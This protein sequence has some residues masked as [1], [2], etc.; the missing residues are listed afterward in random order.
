M[1]K[2]VVGMSGGVDSA[3]AALLLKE[4][5]YEV[6]GVLLRTWVADDGTEGRCCEIDDARRVAWKLHIPFL[7]LNCLRDF[8]E[9]VTRP[10][11][12]DYLAG[13]TPNPCTV[14]NRA[15]KW[16]KL[17]YAAN[18]MQAEFVATGHYASVVHLPNGRYSVQRAVHAEKDQTYMLYQLSQ[19]MLSRTLMPLATYSKA[20]VR[21]MAAAAGLAVADKKDSQEICFVPDGDYAGYIRNNSDMPIPGEGN[22][23]DSEGRILGRHQ[24]ILHYTVGQR[25]GLGIALGH[26]VFV[27]EIRADKNEVVLSED[28]D[29][30]GREVLCGELFFMGAAPLAVGERLPCL[31]KVRYRHEAA[32][33]VLEMLDFGRLR[34]HFEDPVRAAAP[35]QAAVFYDAD[36]C[37]LGGGTI[38]KSETA[39][40]ESKEG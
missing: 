8:E 1:A 7:A 32:P 15:I 12:R 21:Q 17:L 19:E 10:F 28:K 35:G 40:E 29:L 3:V 16:E 39:C 31:A 24:G 5:G 34:I 26:P 4:A 30:Y 13:V 11:I 18:V 25:K 36:G 33:A 14:C 23:V 6:V 20:K 38:L 2:V 9:S 22:Y 27:K 37:V